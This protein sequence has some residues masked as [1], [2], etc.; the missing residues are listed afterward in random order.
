MSPFFRY[1]SILPAR[2]RTVLVGNRQMA[3]RAN[4]TSFILLSITYLLYFGQLGVLVPYLG[5]FLDGRGFSS[6]Q[7]GQ[8]FALITVTRIFGPNLWATLADKRGNGLGILRLGCFLTASTFLTVFWFQSY[9]GIALALGLM[10]CFWTAVLPQL[11]V[12]TLNTVNSKASLYSRIRLWGSVGYIL[13][14]IAVGK[15]IDISSSEAPIYVSAAILF[16]LF[17]STL[18]I[19]QPTIDRTE[20]S[21]AHSQWHKVF[22]APFVLFMLSAILLQVSFGPFYSFFALYMRD[23]DYSGQETGLL[24]ALGVA[25][26]VIIFIFA[27]RLIHFFGVKR[28]LFV[29]I[30]FTALRW[31]LLAYYAD[32]QSLLI[33]SQLLHALSFGLIHATSVH[34]IHHYFSASFQSRGQA[35]YTSI[36]FGVGGAI[37]N[38]ASGYLWLQGKGAVLTF[39]FATTMAIISALLILFMPTDTA[40]KKQKVS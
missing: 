16:G 3:V 27:G 29:S 2:N 6:E 21:L 13:M 26:E 10:M 17:V 35:L 34:F 23:L 11:E 15:L 20:S 36:A 30:L 32:Q 1:I 24:I 31:W 37:G 7:I 9:W 33:F 18:F 28:V 25:A 12:I 8:L 39:V 4:M 38:L 19:Q 22:A 40:S 5:V 14:A